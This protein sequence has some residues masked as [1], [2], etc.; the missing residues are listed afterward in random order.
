[1]AM[2][3]YQ[4]NDP[5]KP[6]QLVQEVKALKDD[7]AQQCKLVKFLGLFPSAK[8][9]NTDIM[10]KESVISIDQFRAT[11]DHVTSTKSDFYEL[12]RERA[13]EAV[14]FLCTE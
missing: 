1:M 3:L 11:I 14:V 10:S 9:C 6:T 4:T 7:I 8:S 5:K 12:S 2:D 13:S